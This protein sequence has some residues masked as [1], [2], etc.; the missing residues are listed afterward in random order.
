MTLPLDQGVGEHVSDVTVGKYIHLQIDIAM[1]VANHCEHR[2]VGRLRIFQESN[3]VPEHE[4]H[5]T[6]ERLLEGYLT[7]EHVA[8]HLLI[9]LQASQNVLRLAGGQRSVRPDKFG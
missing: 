2:I 4:R 8:G 3:L 7:I 1:R 6:A 9:L 5:I